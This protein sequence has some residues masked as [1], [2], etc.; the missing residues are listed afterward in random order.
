MLPASNNPTTQGDHEAA[1]KDKVS[2]KKSQSTRKISVRDILYYLETEPH[3]RKSALLY[4][5]FLKQK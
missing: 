3:L 1:K 2:K 5:S 4:K